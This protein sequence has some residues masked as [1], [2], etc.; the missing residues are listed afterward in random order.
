[1][2]GGVAAKSAKDALFRKVRRER[3]AGH[4]NID[5]SFSE[6]ANDGISENG[7]KKRQ[8]SIILS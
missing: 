2:N 1:M 7:W 8:V 6:A 4:V 5:A 3:F